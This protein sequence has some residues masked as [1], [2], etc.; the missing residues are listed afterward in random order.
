MPIQQIQHGIR[1]PPSEGASIS[2][3]LL[4]KDNYALWSCKVKATFLVAKLWDLV[5]GVRVKPVI[6]A[7]IGD[8]ASTAIVNQLNVHTATTTLDIYNDAYNATASLIVNTISDAQMY[9]VR[10]VIEDLVATWKRLQDKFERKT[11][12]AVEAA[13]LQ[14]LNF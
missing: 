10:S 7:A 8:A 9:Y 4:G 13:Q 6:P 3:S 5:S 1:A 14:L 11:E 2:I 12:M